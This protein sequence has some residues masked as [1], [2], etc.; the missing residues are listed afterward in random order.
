MHSC[1]HIFKVFGR[2]Q[3]IYFIHYHV[4][5]ACHLMFILVYPNKWLKDACTSAVSGLQW[6]S[7]TLGDNVFLS[8]R[9]INFRL[10]YSVFILQTN[11][12]CIKFT[13]HILN[14]MLSLQSLLDPGDYDLSCLYHSCKYHKFC[15]YH[16]KS[17]Q[18]GNNA[19]K[20]L[21]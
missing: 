15:L 1:I 5:S 3:A 2:V 14:S 13:C 11:A 19:P 8:S 16:V 10:I 6:N 17:K 20:L 7:S 4:L 9:L 12:S 18:R 21:N